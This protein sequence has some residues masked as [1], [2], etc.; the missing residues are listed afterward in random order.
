MKFIAFWRSALYYLRKT[1]GFSHVFSF[2][3]K[4]NENR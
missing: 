1:Q 2:S 3:L 4:K